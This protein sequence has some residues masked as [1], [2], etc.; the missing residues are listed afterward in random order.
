MVVVMVV[1]ARS[2]RGTSGQTHGYSRSHSQAAR[3]V[4]LGRLLGWQILLRLLQSQSEKG[5]GAGY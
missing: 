3:D 4:G 1:V 2:D 5:N